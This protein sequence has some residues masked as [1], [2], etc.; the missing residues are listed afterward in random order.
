MPFIRVDP[1]SYD[2]IVEELG[3]EAFP[4]GAGPRPSGAFE[5]EAAEAA[6]DPRKLGGPAAAALDALL[7]LGATRFRVTYDGGYDEG[8]SNPDTVW[9][10]DDPRPAAVVAKE[11]AK[12]GPVALLRAAGKGPDSMHGNPGDLY[13]RLPDAEVARSALD[14]LAHELASKLLGDG[15]GTGEYQLYGAFTADLRT[16]RMTDDPDARKPE[17]EG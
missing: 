6:F 11:L 5:Y 9:V 1:E 16:G 17:P 10:G 14:E 15:F 3:P 12:P 13:A 2:E 7:A 8:F 4:A